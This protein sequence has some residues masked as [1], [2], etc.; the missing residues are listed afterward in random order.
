MTAA[1]SNVTRRVA[2]TGYGG[3]VDGVAAALAAWIPLVR[4][5]ISSES[6]SSLCSLPSWSWTLRY[7]TSLPDWAWLDVAPAKLTRDDSPPTGTPAS[8]RC[9][10]PGGHTARPVCT[11]AASRPPLH[12]TATTTQRVLAL[13]HAGVHSSLPRHAELA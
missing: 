2:L 12:R 5:R 7:S 6:R 13:G 4:S 10:I 1:S 8:V 11:L 3:V 9:K